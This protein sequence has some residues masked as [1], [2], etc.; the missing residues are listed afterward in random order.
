MGV[1][2]RSNAWSWLIASTLVVGLVAIW[3]LR[4]SEDS[5]ARDALPQVE[6]TARAPSVSPPPEPPV[7][8][9]S[10][11]PPAEP[12]RQEPVLPDKEL[13]FDPA[14]KHPVDL[15]QLRERMPDNLYWKIGAPTKDPQVLREREAEERRWNTLFGKV[16]SSTATEEEIHEYYAHR[17]QVSEDFI[18]FARAVLD[19]YGPQLPEQEKG[20]Y[21]LSIRMHTTRL[22]ELPG[23]I[24]DAL[25]R[26][27]LQD[28]RREQWQRAQ[29]RP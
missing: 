25:A 16:Q 14:R 20:L 17:R 4:S 29:N 26:K 8:A 13:E 9:E 12:P 24:D 21:E 3:V 19:Q 7:R 23:Q 6:R 22:E 11:P 15:A 28:G 27:H 5:T 1:P 18:A 2:P 10:P